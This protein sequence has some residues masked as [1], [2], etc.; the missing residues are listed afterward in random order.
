MSRNIKESEQ[1]KRKILVAAKS[2]FAEK[3]FNGARMSSIA[4]KAGVN[5]AL[6]HYHFESKENL[7][8]NIFHMGLGEDIKEITTR[9]KKEI[10]SWDVSI[11]KQLAAMI[12]LL[13]SGHI[14]NHDNDLNRII[15]RE[16]ADG[17]K[18]FHDFARTYMFPRITLF[19][20]FLKD[21]IR[22]GIFEISN[23]LLFA[24]SLVA[25]VS[26]YVHGEDV[27][28]E[29]RW[30]RELY[31]DKKKTLYNYLIETTFKTLSP[32]GKTITPPELSKSETS[33]L[34]AIVNEITELY[35]IK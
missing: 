11:E 26:D 25:F 31:K 15:A 33:K 34:D 7:Y 4:M 29:T 2:E 14:E 9:I 28:R 20:E 22:L 17:Q 18:Y 13:V 30:H 32:S 27:I 16:I 24:I 1:T 10:Q 19:E 5:Q 35:Q 6:L 8:Q 23:P 3:G 12:Y 21:G